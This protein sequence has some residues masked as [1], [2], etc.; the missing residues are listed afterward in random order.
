MA[1][2]PSPPTRFLSPP[3]GSKVPPNTRSLPEPPRRLSSPERPKIRSF[4]SLPRRL[5]ALSDPFRKSRPSVPTLFTA[6]ANPLAT[7]KVKAI[8]ATT[9]IARLIIYPSS[10]LRV[11]PLEE[12]GTSCRRRKTHTDHDDPFLPLSLCGEIEGSRVHH[13][14]P[15]PLGAHLLRNAVLGLCLLLLGGSVA[16]L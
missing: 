3:K 15:T 5:S 4:A 1:S 10:F 7:N 12:V 14:L 2:L 6:S 16:R 9:N 11:R 8:T 13:W